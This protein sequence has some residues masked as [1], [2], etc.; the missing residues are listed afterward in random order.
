MMMHGQNYDDV[1]AK[2]VVVDPVGETLQAAASNVAI[3]RRRPIGVGREDLKRLL[4]G[5]EELSAQA[6][7]TFLIPALSLSDVGLDFGT[8]DEMRHALRWSFALSSGHVK[9]SSGLARKASSR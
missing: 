8:E 7:S 2:D 4:K 5:I 3:E 9:V 6:R 1:V